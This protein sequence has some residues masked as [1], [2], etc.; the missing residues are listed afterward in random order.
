MATL[1]GSGGVF[2]FSSLFTNLGSGTTASV[3][4]AGTTLIG[5]TG[6]DGSLINLFGTGGSSGGFSTGGFDASFSGG[7]GGLFSTSTGSTLF[8]G[9][10]GT[11]DFN[12]LFGSGGT[13]FN[14][15]SGMPVASD[16]NQMENHNNAIM[17]KASNAAVFS[18][19]AATMPDAI[20]AAASAENNAAAQAQ[21][22]L[23]LAKLM[24]LAADS[25]N[26]AALTGAPDAVNIFMINTAD[27][28]G[29]K[30]TLDKINAAKILGEGTAEVKSGKG[31]YLAVDSSSQSLTGGDG[32]DTLIANG[33]NDTLQGGAGKDIFAINAFG[34]YTITDFKPG[35]DL[36]TFPVQGIDSIE[37]LLPFVSNVEQTATGLSIHFGPNL[38]I[39]LVGMT[40]G[41]LTADMFRF[42]LSE[43]ATY[44]A[45][46]ASNQKLIGGDGNDT[47]IG[48]GGRDTL[49]GGAGKDVFAVN[50]FGHY[51]IND[52]RPGQD[53]L[54][55]PI[56]G[57][58][59]IEKLLPFVSNVEQT[60]TGLFIGFGPN[61]SITLVGVTAGQLTADMFKFSLT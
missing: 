9:T 36:L 24:K 5:G 42:S 57:I 51:T 60:A 22:N 47:L 15:F 54:A 43:N 30:V 31:T 14:F 26:E 40:A 49:Q 25:P 52:F 41:Q 45:G 46:D 1:A 29:V 50:A 33:G 39:T 13:T 3:F 37:E 53:L 8:G 59:S 23:V 10:G 19:N 12:S 55:F 27:A 48:G 32:D 35:Q 16:P 21:I 20:Q 7:M 2:D 28:P 44:L 11:L 6:L 17:P 61:L 38:S 58:D 18:D 4:G 34:H 56:Q